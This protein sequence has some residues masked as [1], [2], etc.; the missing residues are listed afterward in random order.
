MTLPEI[1]K[2]YKST[3]FIS[4]HLD[5]AA[6]SVGGLMQEL[7]KVKVDVTVINI[8][9]QAH[10]QGQT[11]SAQKTL[12][13]AKQATAVDLFNA[14]VQE[15][16]IALK[17]IGV[18]VINLKY[19]DALWRTYE[20]DNVGHKIISQV[21]PE[22]RHIYPIYRLNIETGNI[23]AKDNLLMSNIT[24]DL[25]KIIAKKPKMAVFCPLGVGK[26]V[27]HCL[28]RRAVE[29]FIQPL[30]WQDQPYAYRQKHVDYQ[31]R[32]NMKFNLIPVN[33]K[34][35]ANLINYYQTQI[36]SLFTDGK[37]PELIEIIY[38]QL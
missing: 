2:N 25:N 31:G 34:Q 15:D 30:Y 36:T 20:P 18:K 37:V 19:T 11:L 24:A 16:A 10:N 14:R 28:V 27:D 38:E 33:F 5:D 13:D 35:K 21:I 32:L 23:S 12:R 17:S 26:H 29:K 7:V 1:I 8:F 9:T 6:L 3:Y 22:F 4:P